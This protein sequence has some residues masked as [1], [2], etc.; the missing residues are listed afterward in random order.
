MGNQQQK[1]GITDHRHQKTE[2]ESPA[3]VHAITVADQSHNVKINSDKTDKILLGAKIQN[4][5]ITIADKAHSV[6]I[7][8]DKTNKILLDAQASNTIAII[9]AKIQKASGIP[10]NQQQLIYNG[11]ELKN[12]ETL[13]NY[14]IEKG[15]SIRLLVNANK[16]KHQSI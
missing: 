3:K 10:T 11:K 2:V 12:N 13:S 1:T 6:K 5:A 16:G 7:N 4:N 9:K 14:K 15:S 8:P